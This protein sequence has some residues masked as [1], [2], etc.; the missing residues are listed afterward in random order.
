HRDLKPSNIFLISNDDEELAKVL[1]FGI[2]KSLDPSDT[3]NGEGTKSGVMVGTP[4]YMS[5]EQAAASGE[6]D[7]STD[8][9]AMGILAFE[10][11]L[12]RL[13]FLEN[14]LGGLVLAICARPL[15]IPS[16]WG[17]VPNG[18]DAWFARACAREPSDR[19][20][21]A[22]EAASEFRAL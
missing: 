22:R 11:L 7:A 16:D 8:I 19:F 14:S 6:V 13:P 20:A 1:D 9:W 2:A 3:L 10:C 17:P 21:S 4:Y 12:G 5:P 18:F 15:P